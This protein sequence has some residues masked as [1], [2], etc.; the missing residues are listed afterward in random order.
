MNAPA[1]AQCSA[2]WV[3]GVGVPGVSG[4]VFAFAVL[5]GGDVILGGCFGSAG[6]VAVNN[7]ARYN[8]V[9]RVWSAMG[10]G[11]PS[12]V[13][14]L[15]VLPDG[16]VIVG[17]DNFRPSRYNPITGAWSFLA[18][19]VNRSVRALAVLP[20]GNL[21][22]G[23]GFSY[24]PPGQPSSAAVNRIAVYDFG[25]GVW[26]RLGTGMNNRVD[27]L[28]V[29]SNG[30]VIAGGVFGTAG[31]VPV[32]YIAR[33]HGAWSAIGSGVNAGVHALAVLPDGDVVV[34]G[35]FTTAGGVAASNI[36][37]CNPT[38]GAWSPLGAGTNGDVYSLAVLLGGDVIA[39]GG[40]STA[41][42]T[43]AA[44]IARCNPATG[45]WST[46][47]SGV[48]GSVNSLG[49]LPGGDLIAGG[50][51][52]IAGGIN[53]V[54][55]ARYTFGI[56]A[57]SIDT[58]PLPQVAC[59]LGT[60]AFTVIAEGTDPLAY[61][62]RKS[63]EPIDSS[64]NPS[65]AT[66][67]LILMNVGSADEGV[68][69]CIV[70]NSCG[71]ITSGPATLTVCIGDFNCDGGIDGGDADAFFADWEAGNTAADVNSDGG[72]DGA[73]VSVFFEHWEAGC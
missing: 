13:Y 71:S 36:A 64:T 48:N 72:I 35:G 17:G 66:A 67:T 57:P 29:L 26:S 56:T 14:A 60:V 34:G 32:N 53:A 65:A 70:T 22:A 7:I 19:G 46:F 27:A 38:T 61:Q 45:A 52:L 62:W 54:R 4:T 24:V 21:V 50:S 69:D 8:P 63:A 43:A 55:F 51:F 2:G 47:G 58:Q 42:G 33:Y 28:A 31:G 6:G 15:T 59:S 9:T 20:G 39:G 73:D 40:Y 37:R 30:D 23:G 16:D 18:D 11:V 68:Y 12:C 41:G 25:S 10:N 1:R 3:P 49:V 44:S 5:P